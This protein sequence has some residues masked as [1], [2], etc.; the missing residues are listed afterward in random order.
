MLHI[1]NLNAWYDRSHVLQGISLEVNKGEIVTLMG[2]NGAG[3][4]T[5][6]RSLMGLLSKRQGKA[7]IDGTSFL[8]L[9]AHERFH[10]GLAYVPE[11]RRI[12]PGLTVKEN[13]ELGVIAQKNR[14]DMSALVDEIAETFPRLKE[15][16][17]QDGTS[18]SGGE[19]QMLAIAR[20]MIAKPKVILLDEPSE[21]IMPVLVEEMFE[22]FAKLKQQGLTILLVE[23]NV[24]QALKISDRAY[25]LDQ[26]EIVFHDTAQNL[27]NNDEIQQKYCAV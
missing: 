17:H 10:L 18:M 6:L 16:L 20:A 5:T 9:P 2:R 24:Q 26:G 4:T 25:I 22:L 12:V 8:D 27:L 23:Q 11:D 21:G 1:E 15:R 3:K 14:G 13:L 7:T 19:Q